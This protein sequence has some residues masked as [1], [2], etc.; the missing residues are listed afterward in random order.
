MELRSKRIDA[1]S[2][3]YTN[4][5]SELKAALQWLDELGV[6]YS[7]TRFD[8]YRKTLEAVESARLLGINPH[9]V[10]EL[11]NAF[12]PLFEANEFVT[13]HQGLAGKGLDTYLLEKLHELVSGPNS[14][15]DEKPQSG[16]S[17]ARIPV[18][19]YR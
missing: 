8:R 10:A 12:A 1:A 16:S 9:V 19:S 13:I 11:L 15:V 18:S 2:I 4:L 7:M 6:A 3:K 5:P 17:L 14:Y